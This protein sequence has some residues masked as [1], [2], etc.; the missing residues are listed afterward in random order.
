MFQD[1]SVEAVSSASVARRGVGTEPPAPRGERARVSDVFLLG[2]GGEAGP[3]ERLYAREASRPRGTPLPAFSRRFLVPT[4]AD[5]PGRRKRPRSAAGSPRAPGRPLRGDPSRNPRRPPRRGLDVASG[6]RR[7]EGSPLRAVR[8]PKWN[9]E[10]SIVS[11][12]TISSTL[13]SLFK[14]LCIFPS[15]YLFAIGLSPV[16]SLGRNLPPVWGCDPKQPDSSRRRRA[17]AFGREPRS[18]RPRYGAV[19]LRGAPFRETCA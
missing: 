13:D 1:G 7:G 19:T 17:S 5:P 11:L 15:R 4:D 14:V 2:R 12:S 16:F 9:G 10:A 3:S 6:R 8:L 18:P